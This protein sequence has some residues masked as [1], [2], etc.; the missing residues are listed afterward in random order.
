MGNIKIGETTST[1]Y[2]GTQEVSKIYQG[3]TKVFDTDPS[4]SAYAQIVKDKDKPKSIFNYE[5]KD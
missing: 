4:G 3:A 1:M 5:N 2:V